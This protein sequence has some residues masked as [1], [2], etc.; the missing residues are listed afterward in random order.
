MYILIMQI[1]I[2]I[3][4]LLETFER[5]ISYKTVNWNSTHSIYIQQQFIL[6]DYEENSV[7]NE[8][9]PSVSNI[10]DTSVTLPD[11]YMLYNDSFGDSQRTRPFGYFL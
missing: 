9:F 5:C 6:S 8:Y 11:N 7:L 2:V 3:N 1:K 10:D 4:Y